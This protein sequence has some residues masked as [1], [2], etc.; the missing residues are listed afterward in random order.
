MGVRDKFGLLQ[1][2][3]DCEA[4]GNIVYSAVEID[5]FWEQLTLWGKPNGKDRRQGEKRSNLLPAKDCP[6]T[7]Q[8]VV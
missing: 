7:D 1:S 3:F 6:K 4:N 8:K 2:N 5:R